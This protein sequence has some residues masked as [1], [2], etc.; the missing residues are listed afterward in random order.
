MPTNLW[1]EP[2]R[3]ETQ[4]VLRE[5]DKKEK[6]CLRCYGK[7]RRGGL[8]SRQCRV[9]RYATR[10]APAA[11][12]PLP[13][14]ASAALPAGAAGRLPARLHKKNTGW[15]HGRAA[16]LEP[17]ACTCSNRR[18][19]ARPRPKRAPSGPAA[20]AAHQAGWPP[21]PQSLLGRLPTGNQGRCHLQGC[22]PAQCHRLGP[23]S[24]CAG[25]RRH[26][27]GCSAGSMHAARA[28]HARAM[29]HA[30]L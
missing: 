27:G 7:K 11:L 21:A 12:L 15:C 19:T 2:V 22:R 24:S 3:Q 6:A 28:T 8:G 18:C 4:G 26:A 1:L 9:H 17:V 20:G 29:G 23:E 30:T 16:G 25:G 10:G 14:T 5:G 13:C